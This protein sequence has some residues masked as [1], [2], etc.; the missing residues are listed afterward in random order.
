VRFVIERLYKIV[1]KRSQACVFVNS[2]DPHYLIEKNIIPQNKVVIIK[3]VGIDTAA[4]SME[5]FTPE[6]L[7]QIRAENGLSGK[8]VVLMVARAIWDKGIR[9]FYEACDIIKAK[10]E[11]VEFVFVGDIDEGNHTCASRE[12]LLQG[13]VKWLGHRDDIIDLTAISDIYVLPS[14]R[15]GLPRV[16]LEAASMSKPIITTNSVGCKEVVD[17]GKNGFLIPV[18]DA[19][20]LAEKVEILIKDRELMLKMGANSRKKALK[21]FELNK[22]VKQY[23]ELYKKCY[24]KR[25]KK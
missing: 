2:D 11:N 15:E 21:E 5:H 19:A 23:L 25:D 18:K 20:A 14:Y 3:S 6:R 16:L 10:Y 17:E 24:E 9:E 22:V 4:F 13:G 12:F 8:I 1:F 7:G